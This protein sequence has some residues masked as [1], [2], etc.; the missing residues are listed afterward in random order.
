MQVTVGDTI[1]STLIDPAGGFDR[2]GARIEVPI[3]EAIVSPYQDATLDGVTWTV[4]LDPLL[5]PGDFLLYWMTPDSPPTYREPIP[6]TAVAASTVT[7]GVVPDF[8]PVDIPS[9]TPSVQDVADLDR[10]R[11]INDAG[12]EV[13]IFDSTTRPSDQD[14]TRLIA[15]A[16]PAVI[17]QMPY[18][19][20]FPT[21]YYDEV[22]HLCTL[23]TAILIEGSFFREQMAAE[24]AMANWRILFNN[25]LASINGS[26]ENTLVQWRLMQRIEPPFTPVRDPWQMQ[27]MR[28]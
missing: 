28:W 20:A 7:S 26:I 8:P 1:T 2:L 23:Y 19:Y 27:G 16:V 10:T 15:Q 24:G 18:G 9:I 4:T 25:G 22:K 6:I 3:T 11:A 14:V 21:E 12:D 13:T 5:N 17:G